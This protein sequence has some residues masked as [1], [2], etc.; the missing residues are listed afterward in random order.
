M[1][2]TAKPRAADLLIL[3]ELFLVGY[4]PRDLLERPAFLQRVQAAIQEIIHLS[5]AYPHTGILFGAPVPTG[6]K[7]GRKLYNSAL[8][9]Y[10]GEILLSQHKSLLPNY[11]VFDEAR[12]FDPA[13]HV[14]M[15]AFKGMRL[16][17]TICEDAWNEPDLW[18]GSVSYAA[19]P[20]PSW[21]DKGWIY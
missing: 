20:S 9:I 1:G 2:Q 3:P 18:K 17:I 19:D 11:D 6:K 15:V 7:T 4:P 14:E 12:Y 8:L 21:P 10:Q 5:L 13:E 16:G